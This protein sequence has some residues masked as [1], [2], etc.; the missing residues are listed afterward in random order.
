MPQPVAVDPISLAAGAVIATL[1][2]EVVKTAAVPLEAWRQDR[3]EKIRARLERAREAAEHAAAG[4]PLMPSDRTAFKAL[5]EAAF[6]DNELLSDYLGGVMAASGPD[7]DDG[8][9]IA[10]LLGRL[11]A[12]QLRF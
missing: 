2:G 3:T 10:A 7:D 8:V 6:S 12:L 4:R 1:G 9:P 11:S 5:S